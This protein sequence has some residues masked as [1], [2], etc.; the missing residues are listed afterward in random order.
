MKPYAQILVALSLCAGEA[1]A[2]ERGDTASFAALGARLAESEVVQSGDLLTVRLLTHRNDDCVSAYAVEVL[3]KSGEIETL[4]FDAASLNAIEFGAQDDWFDAVAGDENEG[5]A[6]AKDDDRDGP[7]DER[8]EFDD[9]QDNDDS[10]GDDAESDGDEP[11]SDDSGGDDSDDGE[12]D[13]SDG[14]SDGDSDG[15]DSDSDGGD[16]D[17]GDGE[18][19]GGEGDGGEGGDSDGG[20]GDGGDG[21]G[22]GDGGD[23][24]GGEG[25]DD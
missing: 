11:D 14:D 2:C 1:A 25:G 7:G 20:E 18:G 15:G 23:G 17:G 9:D 12:Q 8:E 6:G 13:G 24:D 5:E 10:D 16:S 22:D 19:D 3:S 4:A 21:D